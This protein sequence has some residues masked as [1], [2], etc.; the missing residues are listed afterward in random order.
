MKGILTKPIL[1]SMVSAIW[2]MSKCT[3]LNDHHAVSCSNLMVHGSWFWAILPRIYSH[4]SHCF[5]TMFNKWFTISPSIYL[6]F[7]L[8]HTHHTVVSSLES[9]IRK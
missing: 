2:Y 4:S 5:F 6:E 3:K 1:A 8:F 9:D 7:V